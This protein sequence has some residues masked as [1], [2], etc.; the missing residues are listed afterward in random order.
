MTCPHNELVTVSTDIKALSPLMPSQ[1]LR[2]FFAEKDIPEVA[3]TLTADN[4]DEHH[5]TN[6]VV[7]EH[8][9]RV[10]DLEAEGLGSMLRRIDF[11]NASVNDY[12]KHLA[13][14]LINRA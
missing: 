12:L 6:V 8:M 10:G 9:T 5:M 1:Y 11:A 4:G 14:A 2:D 7:V 3:W 13:G